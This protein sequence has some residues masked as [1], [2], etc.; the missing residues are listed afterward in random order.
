M[1]GGWT[2]KGFMLFSTQVEVVVELKVE[3]SLAIKKNMLRVR[4]IKLFRVS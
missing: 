3:L 2:K 4:V 1:G